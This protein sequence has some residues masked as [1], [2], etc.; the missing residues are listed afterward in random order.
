MTLAKTVLGVAAAISAV[1]VIAAP[2]IV[3]AWGDNSDGGRP[4]YTLEQINSGILGDTITFNSISNSKIGDE[5]NF[6]AASE[7]CK[8]MIADKKQI[9]ECNNEWYNESI[10]VT[11][12]G[13]YTIR[14]Y[15]HNNNPKGTNAVAKDVKATVSLPT[16]VAKSHTI[17][18]YIDSS[19][20][21]PTRYWDEVKLVSDNNFYIE[22]VYGSGSYET[23]KGVF[24]LPDELITNGTAL[25]YDTL[26]GLIPGCYEYSGIVTFEVKV[27]EALSTKL[28]QTVRIAGT[29]EWSDTVDAKVGDEVEYQIE[30]QNLSNA[31]VDNVMIRDVLP[32]NVEYVAGSTKLYNEHYPNWTKIDQDNLV[33]TGINIG[34]YKPKGNAYIRFTGKVVNKSLTGCGAIDQLV[35]WASS[36]VNDEVAKDNT[37][38]RVKEGTCIPTTPE[39]PQTGASDILPAAIGAGAVATAA[40]YFIASRKKLM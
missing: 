3:N 9:P 29:K 16:T 12:G 11:N 20:A 24:R 6:V 8:I 15:V 28:K 39:L 18:G 10:K 37:V 4:S 19:N 33:T 32:K 40:G 31:Q 30:F 26:N 7:V 2:S 5:K 22:Y 13:T 35:N 27:T 14:L 21:T 23:S 1:S 25:G 38:V 36:T 17:V 34:S